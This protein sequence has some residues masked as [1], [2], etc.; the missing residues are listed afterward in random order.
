MI[1][2]IDSNIKFEELAQELGIG[3]SWFRRMFRHYTGFAPAQYLLQTKLNKAKELVIGTSLSMKQ[4]SVMLGFESQYYFS[5][6]FK[7]K[8]GMSPNKMRNNFQKKGH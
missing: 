6:I 1:D 3:Y 8:M 2:N 5:K 4:I 7:K